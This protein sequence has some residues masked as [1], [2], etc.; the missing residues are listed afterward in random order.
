MAT[1]V[2]GGVGGL[3]EAFEKRVEDKLAAATL[4]YLIRLLV[5]IFLYKKWDLDEGRTAG[6]GVIVMST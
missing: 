6:K 1:G 5:L 4:F 3:H 2:G